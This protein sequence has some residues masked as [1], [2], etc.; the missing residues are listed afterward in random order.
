MA[1][2]SHIMPQ[3][4]STPAD[5]PAE[6]DDEDMGDGL[7]VCETCGKIEGVDDSDYDI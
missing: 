5:T 7:N 3:S 4:S 6:E 1:H 2:N